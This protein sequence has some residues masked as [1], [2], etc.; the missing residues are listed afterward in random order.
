MS[1]YNESE[2]R[3]IG[4]NY[5]GSLTYGGCCRKKLQQPLVTAQE[6][7]FCKWPSSCLL[8]ERIF[9]II[10]IGADNKILLS[11]FI[12]TCTLDINRPFIPLQSAYKLQYGHRGDECIDVF[13]HASRS[14]GE[15]LL[16]QSTSWL[17][18]SCNK[19]FH[20][21]LCPLSGFLWSI[22]ADVSS[23]HIR[24]PSRRYHRSIVRRKR[25]FV[26]YSIPH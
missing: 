11:E 24:P 20:K 4:A 23:R 12:R 17:F 2:Y 10:S 9:P 19:P 3:H 18:Q 21:N 6:I 26:L 15:G 5:F 8:G 1:A 16:F 13:C 25:N 7:W 22:P 14:Y